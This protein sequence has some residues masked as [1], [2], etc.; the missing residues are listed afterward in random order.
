MTRERLAF[1]I[2]R[3]MIAHDWK[4]DV[5]E[6]DWDSQAVE[7]AFRIADLFIKEGEITN[8]YNQ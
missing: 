5:S 7:R 3:L 8:V 6:K 1:S 4:F 2:L